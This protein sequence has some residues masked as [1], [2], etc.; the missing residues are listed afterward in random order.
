M[1]RAY[2]ESKRQSIDAAYSAERRAYSESKRYSIDA[3]YSPERRAYSESKH[4]SLISSYN[5]TIRAALG[6]SCIG[7]TF[8]CTNAAS[9][10]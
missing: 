3:A 1:R 7:D 10:S 4:Q 2:G 9:F 5:F 6:V 8:I